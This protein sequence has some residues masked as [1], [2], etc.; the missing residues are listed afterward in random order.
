MTKSKRLEIRQARIDGFINDF[1][2][3]VT[4]YKG[5]TFVMWGDEKR[6][7][8]RM[9]S[10]KGSSSKMYSNYSYGQTLA[11]SVENSTSAEDNM[12]AHVDQIKKLADEIHT[13]KLERYGKSGQGHTLKVDDILY[14]SWGYD[15]TNVSF[16]QVTGVPS[17]CYVKIRE[18]NRNMASGSCS[19][20]GV[21][22]PRIDDF[23]GEELRR[24]AKGSE[25]LSAEYSYNAHLYTK[26]EGGIN[27]S[28]YA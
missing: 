20:S 25:V 2:A 14:T 26:K 11:A 10:Y 22:T 21:V 4:E 19:M 24:M 17:K 9:V 15:Q 23:R 18:I 13:Y 28:W 3:T 5:F 12:F 27:C 8:A 1:G 16:F 6:N 7:R